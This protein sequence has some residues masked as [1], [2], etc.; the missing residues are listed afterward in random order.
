LFK[1]ATRVEGSDVKTDASNGGIKVNN[2][3]VAIPDVAADNSIIH[4]TNPVVIPA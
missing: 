2:A 4:I 3:T 1:S